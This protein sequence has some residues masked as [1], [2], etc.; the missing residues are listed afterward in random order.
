MLKILLKNRLMALVDQFTG[1]SK[2]KKA[3]QLGTYIAMAALG[4]L[5][6]IGGGVGINALF[7]GF[8]AALAAQGQT[9]AFFAAAGGLAF[10][11]AMLLTLFYAQGVVFEA[12]DNELLLSMPIR[13]SAILASRIASVYFLN[14]LFS[15]ILMGA[16]GYTVS[17]RAG[18]LSVLNVIFL[19][20]CA[21]LLPLL[22]TTL[23]C[24]L[25]WVVSVVTRRTRKKS[26]VQ[27]LLSLGASFLLYLTTM[28]MNRELFKTMEES[29]GD[30][31]LAFRH[32]VYPLY[33]MGEAVAGCSLTHLLIFAACCVVPFAAVYWLLS[34]SFIRIVTARDSAKQVKYEATPLKG[35]SVVWSL[36]K[37]DLTRFFNS[38]PYMLNAGLGLLYC[39]GLSVITLVSGNDLVRSVLEQGSEVTSF[40]AHAAVL[41]AF[42]LSFFA[43]TTTISGCSISVEGKNLWILK[44]MPVRAKEI[45]TAKALS[46]LALAIPVSLVC[47]VLYLFGT[48]DVTVPGIML[49]F[50]MP[51][52]FN[53]FNALFGL[54]MNLYLG[55]LN[56]PSIARASKSSAS[57]LIPMLTTILLV[58]GSAVLFFVV[59]SHMDVSLYGFIV[60]A[61][62]FAAD[63][64]LYCFLG[65]AAAQKRWDVLGT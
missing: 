3:A 6:M 21:L 24:L 40:G 9:W 33:A 17:A 61:V 38:P 59:G 49:M 64:A 26:L 57:S 10:I 41:S 22:S 14:A 51:L 4:V 23:S 56:Y 62:I 52:A 54:I 43:A 18:G 20:L 12:K 27:V 42:T 53:G 46:H 5:L 36:T 48:P 11:L 37:K 13:P 2:G 45:L 19:I 8:C 28:N 44:S 15:L 25:A 32:T 50:L 16:A 29:A 60:T 7:G 31:A 58:G 1:Q 35:S 39:L 65:S 47:S 63:A 30:I 55:K 34:R